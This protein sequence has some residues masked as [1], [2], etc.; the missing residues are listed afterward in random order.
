MDKRGSYKNKIT[1][2]ELNWIMDLEQMN[3]ESLRIL[4][5]RIY[6]VIKQEMIGMEATGSKL[7][8]SLIE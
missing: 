1:A 5:E 4:V 3:S 8:K 7:I 6:Y 2:K